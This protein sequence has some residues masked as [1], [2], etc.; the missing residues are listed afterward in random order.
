MNRWIRRMNTAIV[1]S[2]AAGLSVSAIAQ[3]GQPATAPGNKPMRQQPDQPQP[4]RPAQPPAGMPSSE[5]MQI[6]MEAWMQASTPGPMHARLARYEGTWAGEMKMWHWPGAD[7]HKATC[8]TTNSIIF[9]GRFLRCEST[10]DMGEMA[11]F[12]GFGLFGF[13]NVSQKF[14]GLW[15]DNMGTGM[16][17]GTGSLSDDGTTFTWNFKYD[18]AVTKKPTYMRMVERFI[19][20]HTITAEV[21]GPWPFDGKEYKMMEIT[22]RRM[23]DRSTPQESKASVKRVDQ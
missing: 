3:Q 1:A 22:Y 12:Q 8:T 19:D 23:P 14:Q 21:F 18:C 10:G 16:A 7:V 6:M 20:D 5:Q 2:L 15:I 13:D 9:D 4:D 11:P 17:I